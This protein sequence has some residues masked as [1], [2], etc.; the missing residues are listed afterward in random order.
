MQEMQ[1]GGNDSADGS[2]SQAPGARPAEAG[3]APRGLLHK[4]SGPNMWHPRHCII[5]A[6]QLGCYAQEGSRVP[7]QLQPLRG[8][9]ITRTRKDKRR[10]AFKVRDKIASVLA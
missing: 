10:F 5:E 4:R 6:H 1:G 9:V 2:T 8:C 7:T 3:N